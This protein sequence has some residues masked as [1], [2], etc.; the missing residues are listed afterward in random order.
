M[1][2]VS[3]SHLKAAAGKPRHALDVPTLDTNVSF[4]GCNGTSF[5]VA[6]GVCHLCMTSFRNHIQKRHA[7]PHYEIANPISLVRSPG[8]ISLVSMA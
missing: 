4:K 7:H 1:S 2:P 6:N 5:R 8:T 3:S